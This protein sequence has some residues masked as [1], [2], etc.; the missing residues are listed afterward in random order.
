MAI[1]PFFARASL[2]TLERDLEFLAD[3]GLLPEIYL[4]AE[5]LDSLEESHLEPLIR[6]REQGREVS[7]HA[8]FMD[9]SPGGLDP[10][11]L[12]VTRHRFLQVRELAERIEPRHIVFHPGYDQWRFGQ[13]PG[14][15]LD[16]SLEIWSES[17]EWSERSGV[18]T[19]L[20]NV[21]DTEPDHLLSLRER[22][23]EGL[24]FCFDTGHFLL[25]SEIALQEWMDAIGPALA[26]LHLH[27]NRGD[28]DDHLPV[29]EGKFDFP[30]LLDH[31]GRNSLAPLTVLEHHSRE[32]T[33][34]SLANMERLLAEA[35]HGTD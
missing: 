2:R 12:E 14:L 22:L 7:F 19:V 13:K 26:E 34:V 11:V 32:E 4:P 6:W 20:E 8:P 35:C 9:L 25:F 15:W 1:K 17:V 3:N 31:L 28:G 10:R 21:F 27:D 16:N 24:G 18:R 33:L 23:G 5:L 30:F 29:G